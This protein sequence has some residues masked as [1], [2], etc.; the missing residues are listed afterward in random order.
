MLIRRVTPD[1]LL[2][3]VEISNWYAF[4]TA[5]NFAVEPEPLKMWMSSFLTT[6]ERF[7]WLLAVDDDGRTL[8]FAK[9]SPYLGRCAYLWSAEVSVYRHPD[10][11]DPPGVGTALY[12]RLFDCLRRQGY[13]RVTAGITLPN[14]ASEALHERF[15]LEV[16]GVRRSIGWKFG[17]WHD[18][19][20]LQGSLVDAAQDDDPP[21]EIR[22]VNDVWPW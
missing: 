3:I 9:A 15:G 5:T 18:V 11:R 1:D 8:G 7:P 16:I 21:G 10:H 19:A 22:T 12:E 17:I 13:R 6:H 20:L 2:E 14:P 4:N